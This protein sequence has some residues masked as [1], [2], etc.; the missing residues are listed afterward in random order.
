MP[1]GPLR[2]SSHGEPPAH[3]QSPQPSPSDSSHV[4]SAND[5]TPDGYFDIRPDGDQSPASI[6]SEALSVGL[7][8]IPTST[9]AALTALQYLPVPVIVLSSLK[10]VVLANEAMGRLL[11]IDVNAMQIPSDGSDAILSITD[12]LHGQSVA[13]LGVDILQHGSPIFISWHDFLDSIVDDGGRGAGLDD[14]KRKA[15]QGIPESGETTPTNF[16]E[17]RRTS[18]SKTASLSRANLGSTTVTDASVDVIISQPNART[19]DGKAGPSPV[20]LQATMIISTWAMEDDEYFTLTFTSASPRAPATAPR[21]SSRIVARSTTPLGK[22]YASSNSSSSGRRSMT[23][24]LMGCSTSSVTSPIMHTPTFPPSGPPSSNISSSSRSIF[25]KASQL[26][27]AILNSVSMPAYAMWK[28]ESFGIPNKALMKL[29]PEEDNHIPGDQ[30]EFLSQFTVWTEDFKSLIGVDDFPIVK[31]VRGQTRFEGM[32]IGLRNP[33]TKAPLVFEVT[34][35]LIHDES[36]GEFMGGLVLFKDVTEYTKRIAEQI[37]ENERQFEYIANLI[38]IMV[39]RTTPDGAH[40]WFSQR[41]YDYT[42][43]SEEESLGAGWR[44]P[45]HEDDMPMTTRRWLHSLATGEE[46]ITEYRCRRHDGMWRWMLGRAVPFYDDRG[47]IVKWFGTCTD[48]HELVEARQAAKDTREQLQR[49]IEHAE[50]TLWAVNKERE[51]TLL[52]GNLLRPCDIGG[53]DCYVGRNVIDV[54]GETALTEPMERILNGGKREELIEMQMTETDRWYRTR[55]LPLYVKSRAAGIEGEAY[56]DGVISVS[57]DVTE[58]RLREQELQDQFKEN[59]KLLANEQAAKEASKMKSQFLANMSHEIRTP[60]AGVIGM[61]ELILDSELTLEQR[62][63]AE[64]IQ[65]SANGLL[66]VINDI[67]DFSKVESGRLDVEEVQFNLSVVIRDVNKMVDFGATRKGLAFES[68]VQP[69]IENDFKV[70]GD[71]GRLRQIIQNLLTNALKFTTEGYLKLSVIILQETE[72]AYHVQ[73]EVADTG[74]GIEEDVRKKLFKPFSQA[75]SSTARRFGGTGLG[76]TISKNLVELMHGSI[77]LESRLGSGTKARFWLP[78]KKVPEQN[79]GSPLVDLSAIPDRL[80]SEVS[81]TYG[82]SADLEATP[83]GTPPVRSGLLTRAASMSRPDGIPPTFETYMNLPAE[84]RVKIHVL[85]VED[86]HVNQQI[87]LKT[88]QK[89]GFSV[90]AVWNG[91]EALDYLLKEPTK[92]APKPNIILMDVQMPVMDGYRATHTIRTTSP[93]KEM[94]NDIPIVAMTASAIQGD[95]EKCTRAGMDDYLSKPVRGKVLEKMLLKW[96]VEGRRKERQL[97][98]NESVSLDS[99]YSIEGT[100]EYEDNSGPRYSP[101]AATTADTPTQPTN[102]TNFSQTQPQK[103]RTNLSTELSGNDLEAELNRLDYADVN[104]LAKA[105]ETTSQRHDRRLKIEEKASSLR[106]DKF[107]SVGVAPEMQNQPSSSNSSLSPSEKESKRAAYRADN[108]SHPLTLSNLQKH[109]SQQRIDGEGMVGGDSRQRDKNYKK[110][111][112]RA[113]GGISYMRTEGSRRDAPSPGPAKQRPD[114]RGM[115]KNGSEL[116]LKNM[117]SNEEVQADLED[118]PPN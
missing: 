110:S 89:L 11:N 65:R 22:Q 73:F 12:V 67:L 70:M 6:R 109:S 47:K 92:E 99:E 30:R 115:R 32:R 114:F 112:P 72:E 18:R 90:N 97:G 16:D 84:E 74:I 27:D 78:M 34:G 46:Y 5:T 28:D 15:A 81:V 41:W 105:S 39:W 91:Q 113:V 76:L 40:D 7:P 102:G 69:E 101:N 35:E 59:S 111:P 8:S 56:I 17:E 57:M 79:D 64:N 50:V 94:I 117:S 54:F 45:F 61:A 2:Q 25:Q 3:N 29:L 1:K 26:K 100:N 80:Q 58:L 83:P 77:E 43:L 51:I 68:Y 36:S 19:P 42:G 98:R 55:L 95:K 37:E 48:I 9:A 52:E 21:P 82:S 60:I 116:T 71:P 75:D 107:L 88:I 33:K 13:D 87:A 106:D 118:A 10:T 20:P 108:A 62:D 31:L 24:S 53:M 49:V 85:V 4:A 103:Q 66:T 93:F 38:P 14:T 63:F 96:A 23:G 44:N 86:N 104:S